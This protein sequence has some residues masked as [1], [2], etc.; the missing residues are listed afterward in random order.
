MKTPTTSWA[1]GE[2]RERR[3]RE[4]RRAHEHDAQRAAVPSSPGSDVGLAGLSALLD[5]LAVAPQSGLALLG[6]G[7]VDDQHAVEVVD[8]VLEHPRVQALGLDADGLALEADALADDSDR[9]ARP[10]R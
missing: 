8:L 10:A 6:R 7:A 9:R 2:A 5:G 1:C 3:H 4:L